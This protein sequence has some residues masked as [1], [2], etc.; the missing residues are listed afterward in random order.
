[1]KK[2][3]F[4]IAVLIFLLGSQISWAADSHSLTA[5]SGYDPVA[6]FTMNKAV[7]GS[8]FHVS[9]FE[10]KNYLFSSKENQK[11]FEKIPGKYV[12]AFNGWCAYGVSVDKKFHTDPTVFA[13]VDGKL[14]LNIDKGIQKKWNKDRKGNI[15]KANKNWKEIKNRTV[16]SL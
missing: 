12:P 13:V 1:M 10:G 5:I 14:Y 7:R 9:T 6:Y 15:K 11:R 8:G 3:T 16:A 2:L 4:S